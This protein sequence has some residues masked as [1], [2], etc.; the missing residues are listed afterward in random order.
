MSTC[1]PCS[2]DAWALRDEESF[3][4]E[5][6]FRCVWF[7][8]KDRPVMLACYPCSRDATSVAVLAQDLIVM[9]M[10]SKRGWSCRPVVEAEVLA[11]TITKAFGRAGIEAVE[12]GH[13][14]LRL[15][16]ARRGG[17]DLKGGSRIL[18]FW[19]KISGPKIGQ[20]RF[21][22]IGFHI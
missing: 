12:R 22:N 5:G 7:V 19:A 9:A 1:N 15:S 4:L 20:T 10:S 21:K 18:R 8:F 6:L 16:G 13:L 2:R 17:D 3:L 11:T 14:A